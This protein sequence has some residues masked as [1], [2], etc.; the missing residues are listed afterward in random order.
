ML[1]LRTLAIGAAPLLLVGAAC[2]EQ[3]S[4]LEIDAM[5]SLCPA[6]LPC[7][8]LAA[9]GAKFAISTGDS[10]VMQRG[11]LSRDGTYELTVDPGRYSVRVAVEGLEPVTGEMTISEG[12]TGSLSLML[13]ATVEEPR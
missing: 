9:S 12:E 2:S 3:E 4:M 5:V 7:T 10:W 6:E 13:T 1:S 11:A 8:S